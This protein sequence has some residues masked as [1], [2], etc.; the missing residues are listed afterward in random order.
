MKAM[1]LAAGYGK[2]MGDLTQKTPKP[3][4]KVGGKPLIFYHLEAL[5]DAGFTEVVINTGWL[6]EQL[7]L[8]VGSGDQFGLKVRYSRELTPLETAGGIRNALPLLGEQPFLV[9]NGDV[10]TEIDFAAITLPAD[11]LAHLVLVDNPEHNLDGDFSLSSQG[12]VEKPGRCAFT[13]SGVGYYHP[14][15]FLQYG[16]GED[17]LGNV[18]RQ[19]MQEHKV[20]GEYF[21]GSWWDIGT[22]ERLRLL[23]Q[24]LSASIHNEFH[25]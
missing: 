19:A 18:L 15:L 17:K 20:S 7:E 2:R 16:L 6:G 9:V 14:Q 10:W 5:A 22:P 12:I 4:L 8:A 3:L 24:Q 13:F 23:D 25:N 21:Q 1:I 11:K